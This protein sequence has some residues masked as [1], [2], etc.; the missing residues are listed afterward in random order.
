ML[1]FEACFPP[2]KSRLEKGV[3]SR[4]IGESKGNTLL[5]CVNNQKQTLIE[6]VKSNGESMTALSFAEYIDIVNADLSPDNEV[7]HV[8]RRI[9]SN[10]GFAFVSKIYHI[11][12]QAKSR[13]FVSDTPIYSFFL[14]ESKFPKYSLLHIVGNKISHIRATLQKSD[15]QIEVYRGGINIPNVVSWTYH[16]ST[17]LFIVL[18]E[19]KSSHIVLSEFNLHQI[20]NGSTVPIQI[21]VHPNSKLPHEISLNPMASMHI[22][23]FRC[24]TNRIFSTHYGSKICIIQQLFKNIDEPLAFSINMY[25]RNF[26]TIISVPNTPCDLPLVY[27]QFGCLIFCYVVNRFVCVVDISQNPPFIS[28][29]MNPYSAGPVGD[30]SSHIPL[31]HH[32]VD[33]ATGDVYYTKLTM[34]GYSTFVRSMDLA[35]WDLMAIICAKYQDPAAFAA[36]LALVELCDDPFAL[37]HF[38]QKLFRYINGENRYSKLKA[39]RKAQPQTLRRQH[40]LFV[41]RQPLSAPIERSPKLPEAITSRLA[42]IEEE[43]PT[44]SF[45]SRK[46]AFWAYIKTQMTDSITRVLEDAAAKAIQKLEHQNVASLMIRNAVD[47][48]ISDY[49]PQQFWQFLVEFALLNETVLLDFPAVTDLREE[50]ELLLTSIASEEMRRTFRAHRVFRAAIAQ[51]DKLSESRYWRSR[52]PRGTVDGTESS[53]STLVIT[54]NRLQSVDG[55]VM[56]AEPISPPTIDF[57]E[58]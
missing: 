15:I 30:C 13:D 2:T 38:A 25:P 32:I 29:Q 53:M 24:K 28:L 43:F 49:K 41:T 44:A 26:S 36:I 3:R 42:Q 6:L 50:S 8:T 20:Q 55:I 21:Q 56:S 37:I 12:S 11:H 57:S 45:V 39:Q 17:N 35:R 23:F 46:K 16:R 48:W 9:T 22:P 31:R 27:M 4:I 18:H 54:T 19:I 14:P 34:A 10:K 58:Q 7:I 1:S 52:I 47:L 51:N 40:S 5:Y 33:I